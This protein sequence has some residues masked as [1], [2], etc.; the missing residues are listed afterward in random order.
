[1]QLCNKSWIEN[2]LSVGYQA[3]DTFQ[4]IVNKFII[5]V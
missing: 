2:V 4:I 5:L 1:M 3:Q